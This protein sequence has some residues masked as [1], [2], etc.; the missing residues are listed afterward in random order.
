MSDDDL[1]SPPFQ[2]ITD[3]RLCFENGLLKGAPAE[4]LGPEELAAV[5]GKLRLSKVRRL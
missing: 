2:D 3:L 1:P 4:K 5:Q